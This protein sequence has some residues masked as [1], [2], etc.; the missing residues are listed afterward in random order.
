MEKAKSAFIIDHK[1][2]EI[3]YLV[4][5]VRLSVFSL[6]AEPFDLDIWYDALDLG[7]TGIVGQG[8]RSKVKVK[9]LK[10]CFDITVHCLLPCFEVKVSV[11]VKGRARLPSATKHNHPQIWNKW[12]SLSVQG[13][14]LCVCNQGA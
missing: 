4:A 9:H 7:K 1:A 6:T 12:W 10:S 2:R 13:I 8:R 3:M 14:C 5:S 11:K